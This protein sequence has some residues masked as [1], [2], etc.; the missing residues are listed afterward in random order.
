MS[1]SGNIES[2]VAIGA[3][4]AAVFGSNVSNVSVTA[5]VPA[6]S[7][8]PA[9]VIKNK[10]PDGTVFA[11]PV[12][13]TLGN[14]KTARIHGPKY[15]PHVGDLIGCEIKVTYNPIAVD[16]IFEI[17]TKQH[18]FL[19]PELC[20]GITFD[21]SSYS[22]VGP[23]VMGG[24][25]F[26][27]NVFFINLTLDEL[28]SA[29][30]SAANAAQAAQVEAYDVAFVFVHPTDEQYKHLEL[31]STTPAGWPGPENKPTTK[32][33]SINDL[34]ALIAR[35]ELK[36]SKRGGADGEANETEPKRL[37]AEVDEADERK[38]GGRTD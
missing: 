21:S 15:K 9:P 18:P 8:W 17:I 11:F 2:A 27:G 22:S 14:R 32:V 30:A 34:D 38:M 29:R 10:I 20:M 19:C 4:A 31:L 13:N 5:G 6:P 1:R 26:Y 33:L 16:D 36:N 3:T 28:K 23:M 25:E 24:G 35:L 7:V 37:K 12:C